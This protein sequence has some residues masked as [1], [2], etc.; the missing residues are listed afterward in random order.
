MLDKDDR[1]KDK[2]CENVR[3]KSGKLKQ[4]GTQRQRKRMSKKG[5]ERERER[6]ETVKRE[7]REQEMSR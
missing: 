2:K 1:K 4:G 6:P 3:S 5:E 7:R